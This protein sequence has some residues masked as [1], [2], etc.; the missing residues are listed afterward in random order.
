V[1]VAGFDNE[2]D[3]TEVWTLARW[4]AVPGKEDDF[5]AAWRAFAEQTRVDFPTAWGTLLRD[6]EHPNVFFS[7][8]PWS[9]LETVGRWRGSEGFKQ[10]VARMRQ[11]LESFEP[12]T[13][14]PVAKIGQ[15]S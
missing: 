6:Q 8:G 13:L 14:D 5:V 12:Y 4:T 11:F 3:M 7:F 10:G 9:D 1:V 2:G 15:S